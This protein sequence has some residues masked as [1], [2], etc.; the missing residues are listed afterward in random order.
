[1]PNTRIIGT[2]MFLP[3]RILTNTDLEALCDTSDEWI[4]KRSGIERRHVADD[5]HGTSDL[6]IVASEMAMKNAGITAQD[7]DAI[8]FCTVTPDQFFPASG[9]LLQG[10]LKANNVPSFDINAACSG[11]LCGFATANSFIES[12]LYKTILLVGAEVASKFMDWD[13]RNTSVLFGDGAG[14]A[15]LQA[16][17]GDHGVKYI[18][19]GTDGENHHVL[20]APGSGSREPITADNINDHPYRIEMD[21]QELFKRAVRKLA[22]LGKRALEETGLTID[23]IRV[24][25]PHQANARIIEAACS[26]MEMPLERTIINIDETGNTIAATIPMAL[27][28]AVMQGRLE[29]GDYVMFATYGA[30][31]TWGVSIV[32]W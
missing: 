31:L 11:Y 3:E 1:M 24:L 2:G 7:L 20:E 4:R 22:E 19:L 21:G 5:A 30:G 26:R 27:H 9:N 25:V 12:G 14:A 16:E 10:M 8:I 28:E 23:D 29:R 15:V 18:E 13:Y 17:E 32:K 6:A